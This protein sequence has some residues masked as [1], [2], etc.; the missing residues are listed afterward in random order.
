MYVE[1]SVLAAA[2]MNRDGSE[3]EQVKGLEVRLAVVLCPRALR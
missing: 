1:V 2:F 3:V